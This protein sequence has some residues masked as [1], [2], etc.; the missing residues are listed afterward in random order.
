MRADDQNGGA[1]FGRSWWRK[2]GELRATGRE[3]SK[4]AAAG[5]LHAGCFASVAA[6]GQL[7]P[8]DLLASPIGPAL[9]SSLPKSKIGG[10]RHPDDD[11]HLTSQARISL[12]SRAIV[13]FTT[14]MHR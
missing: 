1:P 5:R 2:V 6:G 7:R 4:R 13:L 3:K 10:S 14:S 8:G 11:A 9:C 12:P